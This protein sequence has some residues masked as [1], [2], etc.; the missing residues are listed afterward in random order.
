[1]GRSYQLIGVW[2]EH[3][4]SAKLKPQKFLL[5][6][7]DAFPWKFAPAKISCYKVCTIYYT[8]CTG[9]TVVFICV[10]CVHWYS[11]SIARKRILYYHI[12]PGKRP[13]ALAAQAPNLRVG[14]CTE[15]VLKWFNY[16]CARAH[17]SCEVSCQGIPNQLASSLC[18][19]F[20]EAS[21]TVEKAV[22]CYK[23]DWVVASLSSFHRVQSLFA[24]H[25]FC[26][27]WEERCEQGHRW[28]CGTFDA[29]CCGPQSVSEQLQ[30]CELGRP[31][32]RFTQ[33]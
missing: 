16:P 4:A 27:T 26:A 23:A 13:W 24:V 10:Y 19:G 29:C 28:V 8:Y 32:F 1:M 11:Y 18:P 2:P 17:P 33:I 25:K 21:Q 15:E 30:L 14:G 6:S 3:P 7:L 12:V 5:K 22:M 20:V 31:T 9:G